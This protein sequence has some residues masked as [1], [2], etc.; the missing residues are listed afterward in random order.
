[1]ESG[2][3]DSWNGYKVLWWILE[4]WQMRSE[5]GYFRAV[6]LETEYSNDRDWAEESMKKREMLFETRTGTSFD[7]L[8]PWHEWFMLVSIYGILF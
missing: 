8:I 2:V 5:Q 3:K 7:P 1:M 4:R 6:T